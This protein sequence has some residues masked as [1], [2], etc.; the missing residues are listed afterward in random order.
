M[1][2]KPKLATA[3][4]SSAPGAASSRRGKPGASH[5]GQASPRAPPKPPPSQRAIPEAEAAELVE[6][7]AM[8]ARQA[9]VPAAHPEAAA[10]TAE[11]PPAEL[12][13]V[14][15]ITL[16][17]PAA[18]EKVKL[19]PSLSAD[20]HGQSSQ[21]HEE[22]VPLSVAEAKM[23]PRRMV[24]Y[25]NVETIWAALAEETEGAGPN[26]RLLRA[27]WVLKQ[28]SIEGARLARRQ[29]LPEEAF[30]SLAEL[31]AL[32]DKSD[33]H[34]SSIDAGHLS[35][36]KYVPV[37]ALSHFWRTK[38]HPDPEG[39]TLAF[40]GKA[41]EEHMPHY[42]KCDGRGQQMGQEK[43]Y[44]DFGSV[45]YDDM[46]L[47]IDWCSLFQEPRESTAMVTAFKGSLAHINIWYASLLTTVYFVTDEPAGTIPYHAR[48]WTTF[49][50]LITWLLQW[51]GAKPWATVVFASGEPRMMNHWG[52]TLPSPSDVDSFLEGGEHAKKIF[53]NGADRPLVARKFREATEDIF[54][55]VEYLNYS[56][57]G[58]GLGDGER[59]AKV[60]RYCTKVKQIQLFESRIG[61]AGVSAIACACEEPG[62]LPELEVFNLNHCGTDDSAYA[63]MARAIQMGA[64]PQLN[65]LVMCSSGRL[66]SNEAKRSLMEV[67]ARSR[68]HIELKVGL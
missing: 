41:L 43:P 39:V 18:E 48:G 34:G 20:A 57:S 5:R 9:D 40:I 35:G 8:F 16:L 61:G 36:P 13:P 46:G 6:L 31:K 67:L 25:A 38:A 62:V 37:I 1:S 60:L 4:A 24:D 56:M 47:F 12:E 55:S 42:A 14:N 50:Y 3:H 21:V 10:A 15:E 53:T 44:S 29:D 54:G 33:N 49:E 26:V 11:L 68:P 2:P 63:A 17:P 30:I 28:S 59:F 32:Y 7:T 51:Q 65:K 58:W 19:Q 23:K 22:V 45:G 66:A 52:Y 64:L 27:S